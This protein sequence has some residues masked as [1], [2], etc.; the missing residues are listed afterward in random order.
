MTHTLTPL[1]AFDIAADGSARPVTETWPEPGP[2]EGAAWRWLHCDRTAPDFAAWVA[3]RLPGAAQSSLLAAETRPRA[4][5][6]EGGL[7]VALRGINFNPGAENED[8]V[9]LR[10]WATDGLVVT[11]RFRRIFAVDEMR[12]EITSGKAPAS[13][14][15]FMVRLSSMLT[16]KIESVIARQEDDTDEV[17]EMLLDDVPD[18]IGA[19]EKTVSRL[20]RAVIK[21]R[22]HIAPQREALSRLATLETPL[23]DATLHYELREVANRTQRVVEDLDT[24]RDRLASL[25]SHIDSVHAARIGQQGFVLSVVAAIFLPL[26]FLTGLFGVNVGGMPG[27]DT[28]WAFAALS[29][30]MVGLGLLLWQVFRWMRWF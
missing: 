15:A 30:L 28:P 1:A 10:L 6:I 29:V 20:S 5:M 25:R 12:T 17:E 22:R 7:L 24:T 8:M 16:D 2:G 4:E 3:E 23:I 18:A 26:G 19:G 27:T 11:S 14:A 9:A 13:P 21:F